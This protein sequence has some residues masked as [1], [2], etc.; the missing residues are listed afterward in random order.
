MVFSMFVVDTHALLWHLTED[1]K[2]GRKAKEVLDKADR[3]ETTAVIPAIILAEAL[4]ILEKKRADL[5]F[6]DGLRK[7]ERSLNY[8]V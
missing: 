4:F 8:V 5:K 3:G 7:I 2:L 1:T 6:K